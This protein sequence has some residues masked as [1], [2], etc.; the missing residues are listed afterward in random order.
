MSMIGQ[1]PPYANTLVYNCC[2]EKFLCHDHLLRQMGPFLDLSDLC[3]P[4]PSCDSHTSRS[5][6][7]LELMIRM[8]IVGYCYGNCSNW[9]GG[10]GNTSSD[11][12]QN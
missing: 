3:D 5:L 7:D 1:T 9:T 4:V 11:Q 8:L 2:L 12:D 10:G 6:V